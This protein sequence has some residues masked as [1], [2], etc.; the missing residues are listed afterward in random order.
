MLTHNLQEKPRLLDFVFSNSIWRNSTLIPVYRK[1]FDMLAVT[2]TT[3]QKKKVEL[4]KRADLRSIWLPRQD[5]NL[6]LDPSA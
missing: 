6:Y 2:N 4:S 1:P 5:S 3:Y